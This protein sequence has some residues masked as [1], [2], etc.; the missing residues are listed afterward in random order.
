MDSDLLVLLPQDISHKLTFDKLH[1][2]VQTIDIKQT[3]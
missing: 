3:F 1:A 2:Q